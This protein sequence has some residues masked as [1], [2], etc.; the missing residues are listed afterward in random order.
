MTSKAE[1]KKVIRVK[2][3]F[4][5]TQNVYFQ[6]NVFY[7]S[8]IK[9]VYFGLVNLPDT[10]VDFMDSSNKTTVNNCVIYTR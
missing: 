2:F 7:K 9:K 4:S 6:Y 8:G 10:V 3:T 1:I 5:H